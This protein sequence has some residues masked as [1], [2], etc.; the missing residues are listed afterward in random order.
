MSVMHGFYITDYLQTHPYDA[1]GV[2]TYLEY[3]TLLGAVIPHLVLEALW[4]T[5]AMQVVVRSEQGHSFTYIIYI[6]GSTG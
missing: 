2:R 1:Y 3:H 6:Y 5:S 4:F